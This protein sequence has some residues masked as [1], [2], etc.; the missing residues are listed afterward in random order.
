M[1]KIGLVVPKLFIIVIT[2]S[3]GSDQKIHLMKISWEIR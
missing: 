3:N 2:V 1:K